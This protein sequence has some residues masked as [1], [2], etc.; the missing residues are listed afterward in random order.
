M[1]IEIRGPDTKPPNLDV[2]STE[3]AQ[4]NSKEILVKPT[5]KRWR[6]H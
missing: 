6:K 2:N 1:Q 4:V 5:C 3:G